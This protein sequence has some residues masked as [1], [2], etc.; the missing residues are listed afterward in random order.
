MTQSQEKEEKSSPASASEL[1]K[2]QVPEI[3]DVEV[4]LIRLAD[5]SIVSRT[6]EELEKES[7]QSDSGVS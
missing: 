7:G 2:F 3:E 6:K 5:G 1:L 4:F